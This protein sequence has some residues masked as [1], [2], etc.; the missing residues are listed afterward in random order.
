MDIHVENLGKRFGN[1]WIFKNLNLSFHKNRS[2]AIT[3]PNGSGK[4]TFL[5]ILAG[6]IPASLGSVKYL[7]DSV[8]VPDDKVF[9]QQFFASPYQELPEEFSLKEL[10]EYH[11]SFRK[12]RN[13][14]SPDQLIDILNL[15]PNKNKE[16]RFYS[17]GMKQRV[18]LGLALYSETDVIILDEP[19]TNLDI[20]NI[21]WYRREVSQRIK[22]TLVLIGSNQPYE[23]DFCSDV[24]DITK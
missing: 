4:S 1:Q 7:E 8:E 18:K 23:F 2:Y 3:G 5:Q 14:I 6:I 19:A 20:Q 24:I 9:E 21:E 22:D 15:G 13:D 17:S 16:I 11:V 12:L 10:L